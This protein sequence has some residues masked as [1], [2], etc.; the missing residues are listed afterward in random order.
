MEGEITLFFENENFVKNTISFFQDLSLFLESERQKD[1]YIYL[2]KY[3]SGPKYN[4]KIKT[5]IIIKDLLLNVEYNINFPNENLINGSCIFI[6]NCITISYEDKSGEK[7]T[8]DFD[9]KTK[10]MV[11]SDDIIISV[12]GNDYILFNNDDV[13]YRI[14]N[15]ILKDDQ[16]NILP[17]EKK[18]ILTESF[19]SFLIEKIIKKN[20]S[21]KEFTQTFLPKRHG[22][23][24]NTNI[25]VFFQD[26]VKEISLREL[27]EYDSEYID[28]QLEN[29][30][31]VY[32]SSFEYKNFNSFNFL[33]FINC[34]SLDRWMMS[35]KSLLEN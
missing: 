27:Y 9:T 17:K 35:F 33:H 14:S 12:I 7:I 18:I 10:E 19:A 13:E 26:A 16:L 8:A 23:C 5:K 29:G 3:T 31:E 32:F 4:D 2:F 25:N 11:F 30:S 20:I 22:P 34:R 28:E 1:R 15:G 24:I 21:E 6:K